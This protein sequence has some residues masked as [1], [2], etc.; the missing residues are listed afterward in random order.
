VMGGVIFGGGCGCG[1]W[2]GF[3]GVSRWSRGSVCV[4]SDGRRVCVSRSV[5]ALRSACC[6]A[7][8]GELVGE[9]IE[10]GGYIYSS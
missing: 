3:G 4:A 1:C 5:C 9:E 2:L 6:D 8:S 10:G 7:G